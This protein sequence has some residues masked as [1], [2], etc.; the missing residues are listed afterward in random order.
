MTE[1]QRHCVRAATLRSQLSDGT[2]LGPVPTTYPYL[3]QQMPCSLHI[4]IFC[5]SWG[6]KETERQI[7]RANKK[8]NDGKEKTQGTVDGHYTQRNTQKRRNEGGQP[9]QQKTRN[10]MNR[11]QRAEK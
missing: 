1:C 6:Y 10:K 5:R 4:L 3:G 7:I 8:V 9:K 11:G 2:L